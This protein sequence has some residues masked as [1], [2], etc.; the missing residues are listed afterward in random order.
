M[1]G[2]RIRDIERIQRP[3]KPRTGSNLRVSY[4]RNPKERQASPRQRGTRLGIYIGAGDAPIYILNYSPRV[5]AAKLRH[6]C[7]LIGSRNTHIFSNSSPMACSAKNRAHIMHPERSQSHLQ[8]KK[9]EDDRIANLN[10]VLDLVVFR[11]FQDLQ[12]VS[13][14]TE[15]P[16]ED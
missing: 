2:Q 3:Q 8:K 4:V 9:V 12:R 10:P 5:C 13:E 6:V 16:Q 1:E 14:I 11:E 15:T 7:Q